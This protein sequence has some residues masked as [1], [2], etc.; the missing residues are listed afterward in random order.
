[1]IFPKI[2]PPLAAQVQYIAYQLKAFERSSKENQKLVQQQQL[3]SLL[4]HAYQYSP[5]WRNRLDQVNFSIDNNGKSF[6][7]FSRLPLLTRKDF[8]NSY[9]SLRARWP[10]INE[11]QIVTAITSGSTGQPIQVEKIFDIYNLLFLAVDYLGN[12]WHLL[13]AEKTLALIGNKCEEKT[14]ISWGFLYDQLG[15]KGKVISRNIDLYSMESHLEWL[16]LIQPNYLKCSPFVAANLAKLALENRQTV[17]ISAVISQ[18]ETV[19]LSQRKLCYDAFGA[20]IIDRYSCEEI[21]WI[22]I[23]CPKYNHL[24][25]M[26]GTVLVEIL[27]LEGQPCGIGQA[28]RVVITGLH[29]YAMPIIRYEIGDI[30][31]WGESCDCG[32]NL[33]VIKK[34]HGRVRHMLRLPSGRTTPM[35][36][37][38]DDI[39]AISSIN[40]FRVLQYR[41][42]EVEVQ[43]NA[44]QK[45]TLEECMFI[46]KIVHESIS[47]MEIVTIHVTEVDKIDWKSGYKRQEFMQVDCLWSQV[48]HS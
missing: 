15:L 42:G 31:E 23:Q 10:E 39:G 30:A 26:S 18:W 14:Q 21:G 38:G 34:L 48:H 43:I 3:Q 2:L 4:S 17:Q 28:G 37:I 20:K 19:S 1:M 11:K 44:K 45:L 7:S 46:R 22:A 6:E 35:P 16:T 9:E 12:E 13:D 29:S 33:P 47:L 27:D 25:I 5:F 36:H 8:Q 41:S 32:I 24:H 40:E